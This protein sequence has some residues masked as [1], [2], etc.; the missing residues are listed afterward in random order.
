MSYLRYFFNE[1]LSFNDYMAI[2]GA[3]LALIL[4]VCAINLLLFSNLARLCRAEK[5]LNKYFKTNSHINRYNRAL[6]NRAVVKRLP[7]KARKVWV[8]SAVFYQDYCSQSFASALK[9]SSKRGGNSTFVTYVFSYIVALI[10]TL[11]GLIA[12][13]GENYYAALVACSGIFGGAV[14][15]LVLA[16]ELYY[17]DKHAERK[18]ESIVRE[19]KSRAIKSE[20]KTVECN[21]SA[22]TSKKAKESFFDSVHKLYTRDF[23]I[24][25]IGDADEKNINNCD[26]Q[27]KYNSESTLNVLND[28]INDLN[29]TH[30]NGAV[31]NIGQNDGVKCLDSRSA[32]DFDSLIVDEKSD[33]EQA[34]ENIAP[35]A[36]TD[37]DNSCI[38]V[39]NLIEYESA[40]S[41][42]ANPICATGVNASESEMMRNDKG[43]NRKIDELETLINSLI[44]DGSSEML[45]TEV[46]DIISELTE[47][48]F[49]STLDLARIKI[50]LKRLK[51]AI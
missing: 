40:L 22:S 47:Y 30:E 27:I 14:G 45:L 19:L 16:I 32:D 12:V 21:S 46:Y 15:L 50:L 37:V 29:A 42:G 8:E 17:L 35:R 44:S 49:S 11:I 24:S 25:V 38:N 33:T 10:F 26:K 2:I 18:T 43:R 5:A 34:R 3:A 23:Q 36:I 6:F 48:N 41:K 20:I 13:G 51:T 4:V 9:Q 28:T 1:I 31:N 7:F 39:E